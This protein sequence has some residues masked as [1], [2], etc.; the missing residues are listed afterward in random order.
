MLGASWTLWT[1]A[2]C[3]AS[4]QDMGSITEVGSSA[5]EGHLDEPLAP[6]PGDD[7]ED[8]SPIING[9]SADAD[10]FPNTGGL[11]LEIDDYGVI[12]MCSS[13]LIA[14]DVVMIA[15]HCV[16]AESIGVEEEAIHSV[17][18]SRQADLT[19]WAEGG[20]GWPDD[21]VMA[22]DWVKHEGFS[23]Y[24]LSY[25]LA[26]NQDIGLVFLEEAVTDVTPAV[27][28]TEDEAEEIAE[29][30]EVTIVGWGHQEGDMSGEYAIKMWGKSD[31]SRL[32]TYEF[33][34][35]QLTEAVRKC[36]GDSGGPT[37]RDYPNTNSTVKERVIGV[38]S[39]TY[40]T[41][42]CSETGGV[43]TRVD[44]YRQWIDGQMSS[45]CR[46]GS[47]VWCDE[48][49]IMAPPT[50]ERS[51]EELADEVHLVGCATAPGRAGVVAAALG[52]ALAL[53][54][55]RG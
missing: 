11:L 39:H 29:E 1:L 44:Y 18:W 47:R 41:S 20:T 38:T 40:D 33:Q 8:P 30:D 48:L 37:F 51:L 49:G 3:S 14:P 43:D 46:D 36:H 31:L 17:G 22:Q 25:G 28:P 45:R 32:A 35:G 5:E 7:G 52:L 55:R 12:L 9:A 26:E 15:A 19:A 10:L 16:D 34:V 21:V 42:D 2:L 6:H 13:T 24:S 4:A 50:I 23:I 27:L 53:R 54:R